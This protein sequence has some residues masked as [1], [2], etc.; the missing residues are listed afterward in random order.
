MCSDPD[1][2]SSSERKM[3]S[4]I[5]SR[6]ESEIPKYKEIWHW[7]ECG[8]FVL[9]TQVS[10]ARQ[11]LNLET[12]SRNCSALFVIKSTVDIFV[13][14][15]SYLLHRTVYEGQHNLVITGSIH[16]LRKQSLFRAHYYLTTLG[17][18]PVKCYAEMSVTHVTMDF[19][20]TIRTGLTTGS[21]TCSCWRY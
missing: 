17:V 21:K 18:L 19:H 6:E 11:L 15:S 13:Y 3:L 14:T 10:S 5:L 8:K 20:G 1:T 2:Q 9:S 4:I 16:L 12:V 7:K